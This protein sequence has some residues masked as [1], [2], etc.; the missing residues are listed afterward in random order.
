M[1]RQSSMWAAISVVIGSMV[2][3]WELQRKAVDRCLN[4]FVRIASGLGKL[5]SCFVCVGNLTTTLSK[6]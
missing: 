6:I 3:V 5:K 2:I 4:L 1:M